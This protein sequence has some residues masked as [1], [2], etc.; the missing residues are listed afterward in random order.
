MPS[1]HLTKRFVAGIAATDV[2]IIYWDD[3]LAG[4]GVRV[5]AGGHKAFVVQYRQGHRTTRKT[6]GSTEVLAL[7][8]ARRTAKDLLA[9]VRLG[10]TLPA[11]RPNPLFGEVLN[12]FLAFV[13]A[14]RAPRTALDYRQRIDAHIRPRFGSKRVRDITR[15]EIEQWHQGLAS[16][17]RNANYLLAILVAT[18]SY[19]VRAK[20]E[21][22]K[23]SILDEAEHPAY[24][25]DKYKENKRT[26]YLTLDEIGAFGI[27]LRALEDE[28]TVSPWAA[29][30]LRLLILTGARSGE[31]LTLKWD[32]VNFPEGVLNL[33]T[34]KT[35]A[36]TIQLSGAALQ[37]LKSIPRIDG[38]EWVIPGRR[39]GQRMTSLQ[40]PFGYVTKRAAIKDCR[41][42][43]LRHSAASIA[44]SAGVGL[45]IVGALLGQS[46]AYT[47]QRYSHISDDASRRAA[48]VIAGKV[49]GLINVVPLRKRRK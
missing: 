39:H 15:A 1:A 18:L 24:G 49:G 11:S 25:I 21:K 20:D 13:E 30:A 36:K 32:H 19:A 33:P 22:S 37:V 26:K 8:R 16:T 9:H 23:Q 40:R 17:P 29:A 12:R 27:A 43:D 7:D 31:I 38:V 46:Q 5:A 4:F 10:Q 47:T 41:I 42:H 3:Q 48:E 6:L 14:K 35:G 45:P 34:S 28:R 44:T 2:T